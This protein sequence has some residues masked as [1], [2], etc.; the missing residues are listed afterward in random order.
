MT[1]PE[2]M[3]KIRALIANAQTSHDFQLV[4]EEIA[5]KRQNPYRQGTAYF[6]A[7]QT[8]PFSDELS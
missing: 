1:S 3:I 6:Y 2:S 7:D 5:V 4:P 8:R